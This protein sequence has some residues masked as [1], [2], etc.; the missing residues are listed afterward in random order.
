MH[1][2]QQNSHRN[3]LR[4][5]R[6]LSDLGQ[7]FNRPNPKRPLVI[8]TFTPPAT[9]AEFYERYLGLVPAFAK[10]KVWQPSRRADL[11]PEIYLHLMSPVKTRTGVEVTDRFSLFDPSRCGVRESLIMAAQADFGNDRE[12]KVTDLMKSIWSLRGSTQAWAMNCSAGFSSP[13]SN[14][15][16]SFPKS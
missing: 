10:Q 4:S 5:P 8:V 13:L 3:F 11:V 2:P 6:L 15:R 7:Y 16:K 1:V 12:I 14:G 9:F